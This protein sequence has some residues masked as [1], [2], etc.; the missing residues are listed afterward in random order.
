MERLYPLQDGVL[1]IVRDLKLPFYLAGGTTLSRFYLH[2]R[3]SYYLNLFRA[4]PFEK[5]DTIKWID[6]FYYST[7]EEDFNVIAEDIFA[8]IR[9]VS[10]RLL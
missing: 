5:S 10:D 1:I 6:G 9:T 8:G 4:F 7:V 3:F 2:H